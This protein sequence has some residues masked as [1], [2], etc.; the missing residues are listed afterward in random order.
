[1][2]KVDREQR[3]CAWIRQQKRMLGT[4][5]SHPLN[6]EIFAVLLLL[7]LDGFIMLASLLCQH[8]TM[9]QLLRFH[10]ISVQSRLSVHF[11]AMLFC[12]ASSV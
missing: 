8:L 6:L 4:Q 2:A 1:M 5:E 10:F 3:Q 11:F 7:D 12:F 9:S